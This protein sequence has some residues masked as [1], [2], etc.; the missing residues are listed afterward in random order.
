MFGSVFYVNERNKKKE[1]LQNSNKQQSQSTELKKK[2]QQL[3][4]R[5]KRKNWKKS[6]ENRKTSLYLSVAY[7]FQCSNCV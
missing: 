6:Q 7:V 2:N 4:K 1:T 5:N 3:N